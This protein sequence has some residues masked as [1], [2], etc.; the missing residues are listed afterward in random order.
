[1]DNAL[2]IEKLTLQIR[3]CLFDN[4]ESHFYENENFLGGKEYAHSLMCYL[5][6]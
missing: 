1:M 6:K 5:V 2:F 3:N 4:L